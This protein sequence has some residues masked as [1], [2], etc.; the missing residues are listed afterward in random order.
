AWL[1][2]ATGNH[3]HVGNAALAEERALECLELASR[4]DDQYAIGWSANNLGV[5]FGYLGRSAEAL[6]NFQRAAAANHRRGYLR[7]LAYAFHN[8]AGVFINRRDWNQAL[9]SLDRAAEYSRE[10]ADPLLLY[11]HDVPRAEALLGLGDVDHAEALLIPAESAFGEMEMRHQQA[12]AVL[13][14]AVC[15]RKRGEYSAAHQELAR[16][17]RL[18]RHTGAGLFEAFVTLELARIEDSAGNT[19]AAVAAAMEARQL[20]LEFGSIF[21]FELRLPDFSEAARAHL[22]GPSAGDRTTPS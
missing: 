7:G 21:H 22:P 2:V 13:Q 12:N 14:L 17:R 11:W 3:M 6:V 5:V 4:A 10:M 9:S 18:V 8:I 20:L 16:A 15:R 19:S 1:L